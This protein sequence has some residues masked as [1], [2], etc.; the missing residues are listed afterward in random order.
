MKLT[1]QNLSAINSS[2]GK[3]TEK[4]NA[5]RLIYE[6]YGDFKVV[7]ASDGLIDPKQT[8]AINSDDPGEATEGPHVYEVVGLLRLKVFP[9]RDIFNPLSDKPE[10]LKDGLLCGHDFNYIPN[11]TLRLMNFLFLNTSI[12][13]G[14]YKPYGAEE[15]E[16]RLVAILA[17]NRPAEYMVKLL[18]D[19]PNGEL[20]LDHFKK[21]LDTKALKSFIGV[22]WPPKISN[23][24]EGKEVALGLLLENA[25]LEKALNLL[26]RL[27]PES[28]VVANF[29]YRYAAIAKER[30]KAGYMIEGL[31]YR[32]RENDLASEVVTYLTDGDPENADRKMISMTS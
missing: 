12:F 9:R 27:L 23:E 4:I 29:K 26:V 25:D 31:G 30:I 22:E 3:V 32:E 11:D 10:I 2:Y 15:Y 8:L 16:A 5:L 6:D 13:A 19:L 28:S 7:F 24:K 21:A 17:S 14:I 18:E 1:F 20:A